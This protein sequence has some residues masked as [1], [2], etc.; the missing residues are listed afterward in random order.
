MVEHRNVVSFFS[1][2]DHAIGGAGPGVWLAVTSIAFD[3]S[4][5]EIFWTL[6]RGF[7]VILQGDDGPR[8]VTD[9]TRSQEISEFTRLRISSAPHH[10]REC[11]CPIESPLRH[12]LACRSCYWAERRCQRLSLNRPSKRFPA[13]STIC[14]GQPKPLSG[15]QPISWNRLTMR[16]RSAARLPIPRRIFL[17]TG[18]DLFRQEPPESCTSPEPAWFADTSIGPI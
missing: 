16:F 17:I 5:L 1:A 13:A 11:S 6:T 9:D 7:K 14:T 4:V 10:W 3:I 15:P 2:M 8:N 12:S 18:R